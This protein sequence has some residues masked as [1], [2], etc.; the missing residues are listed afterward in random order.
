MDKKNFLCK[1]EQYVV[2]HRDAISLLGVPK[3]EDLGSKG[4]GEGDV[5]ASCACLKTFS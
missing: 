1:R 3:R 4:V 2:K 5:P